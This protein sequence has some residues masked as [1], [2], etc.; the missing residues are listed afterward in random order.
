MVLSGE[1]G[2][3]LFAGYA[4]YV[5]ESFAPLLRP[6]PAAV[7]SG[8]LR[9]LAKRAS[10]PRHRIALNALAESDP[11][12]RMASWFPL[13]D[14]DAK[15]ALLSPA[16]ARA[17]GP[18]VEGAFADVLQRGRGG[19]DFLSRMLY[20]DTSLWLPDDLLARGDKMAMAASLELR[21]PLLDHEVVQFAARVPS[22]MKLRRLQRKVLLR[23]VSKRLLPQLVLDRPKEG[24]P[25]PVGQWFRGEARDLLVDLL[26]PDLVRRRGLFRP[27]AVSALLSAH[28]TRRADHSLQ[29]WGLL[30]LELWF[31]KYLEPK[32]ETTSRHNGTGAR[33]QRADV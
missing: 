22:S 23:T 25:V 19:P 7:R 10:N 21:V 27:E 32:G 6:I 5:G 24:F 30:A 20:C 11:V 26:S 29:L 8:A 2:D 16:L 14:D 31:Q 17:V 12:T 18:D 9:R 3:E 33:V 1:G 15:H 13:L 4:R 28:L